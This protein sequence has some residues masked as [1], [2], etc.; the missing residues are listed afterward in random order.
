M[1]L[2]EIPPFRKKDSLPCNNN[3]GSTAPSSTTTP[4]SQS[5]NNNHDSVGI[6]DHNS[7]APLLTTAPPPFHCDDEIFDVVHVNS[8]QVTKVSQSLEAPQTQLDVPHQTE[9]TMEEEEDCIRE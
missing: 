3:H 7:V 6:A 2:P 4:P 8:D 9:D 1:D 5:N